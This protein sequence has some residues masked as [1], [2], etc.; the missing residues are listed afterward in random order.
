MF[1]VR[2]TFRRPLDED[3]YAPFWD[4][5]IDLIESRG[6][7]VGGLGGRLPLDATDGI[8]S[9]RGRGSP[10]DED[11]QVVVAWLLQRAEVA[12]AQAGEFFDGWY[13]DGRRAGDET[14]AASPAPS[15]GW[16]G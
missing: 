9:A 1:E 8:V 16:S 3:A 5:F 13:G 4:A 11:R 14:R 6:L 2:M 15:H 10:S 12:T 7:I